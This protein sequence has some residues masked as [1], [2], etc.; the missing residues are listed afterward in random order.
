MAS[1]RV[2]LRIRTFIVLVRGTEA[3]ASINGMENAKVL[4]VPV[5]AVATTSRPSRSG[6]MACAWTGVGV[7]NSFL[8]RLFRNAEQ[9]LSSEKC[10]INCVRFFLGA[11]RN[12]ITIS[13]AALRRR[14]RLEAPHSP[15]GP[16]RIECVIRRNSHEP[17]I[18]EARNIPSDTYD[19][20]RKPYVMQC[21]MIEA[22]FAYTQLRGWRRCRAFLLR[23][24]IRRATTRAHLNSRQAA[25]L[26]G[27][28]PCHCTGCLG[29]TGRKQSAGTSVTRNSVITI[30]A[31]F[32]IK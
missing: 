12:I 28:H 16:C 23:R 3:R 1:S 25:R 17:G 14:T 7:T 22:C 13:I 8:S 11:N 2:G 4:P 10:C 32:E 19:R 24:R 29:L 18:H 31:F 26:L 21:S 9:R 20:V 15:N 30:P 6:G 5:C 27:L